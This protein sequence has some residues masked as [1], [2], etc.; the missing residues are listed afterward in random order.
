MLGMPFAVKIAYLELSA[1]SKT[2]DLR[3]E[4][5]RVHYM[6]LRWLNQLILGASYNYE[7]ST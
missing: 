3:E 2:A 4:I 6:T 7:Q 5:V 1:D